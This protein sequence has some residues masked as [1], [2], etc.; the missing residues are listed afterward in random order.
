MINE[1]NDADNV[2]DAVNAPENVSENE[3]KT[4]HAE[5]Q[6]ATSDQVEKADSMQ[7]ETVEPTKVDSEAVEAKESPTEV[8]EEPAAAVAEVPEAAEVTAEVEDNATE[9]ASEEDEEGHSD[10]ESESSN[11][12]NTD[13]FATFTSVEVLKVMVDLN[14]MTDV[15]KADRIAKELKS[16]YDVNF[17]KLKEEALEK[18]KTDGNEASDFDYHGDQYH[19]EIENNFREIRDRKNKHYHSLEKE[20]DHNLKAKLEIL[21]QLRS[22]VDSEENTVS[23]ESLK[24][25]QK[26]WKAIGPVPNSQNRTIWAN[27]H[28][29]LDRFYDNRSIYF[30]LKELDRKKNQVLKQELCVKMEELDQEKNLKNAV[31]VLNELHEEYKH[32][33]PVPKENQEELWQRFK[34]ASDKIYIKRKEYVDTLK[35]TLKE[36]LDQ[37]LVLAEELVPFAEFNSDRITEWNEKTKELL[38]FQKKWEAIGGLPREQAKKINRQFWSTFKGFF[39]NKNKFFKQLEASRGENL[40]LKEQLIARADELKDSEDWNEAANAYKQLQQEWKEIGPVP[41][42]VRN[43]LYKKFKAACDHFF[44][45]RRD[46]GKSVDKEFEANLTAKMAICEKLE[47]LAKAEK[48]GKSDVYALQDQYKSVGFVPRGAMKKLQTTYEKALEAVSTAAKEKGG[49]AA[50]VDFQS[51][52]SSNRNRGGGDFNHGGGGNKNEYALKRTI[53][54]LESDLNTWKTNVQFLA[55]SPKADKLKAQFEVRIQ[56]AEAEIDVLKAQLK[57]IYEE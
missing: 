53:S 31:K 17:E 40:K 5:E 16:A 3:Q 48:I 37:K 33:G 55:S 57:N 32:I 4:A 21:E 42:K 27:Y 18:F 44:N 6:N 23:I 52:P 9:E 19:N 50:G 12:I 38:E 1:H 54:Q 43:E 28:A 35:V 11:V 56:E 39:S 14:Q 13:D 46:S 47:Q 25:I 15:K 26:E 49:D 10:D 41:E 29:L 30:E 45:K 8:T 2:N 20:K 7:A 36:N 34:A 51:N 24:K 22:L